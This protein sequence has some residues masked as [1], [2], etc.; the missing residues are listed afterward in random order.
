MSPRLLQLGCAAFVVELAAIAT[1]AWIAG[2][3]AAMG[4]TAVAFATRLMVRFIAGRRPHT[5]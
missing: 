3:P 5:S 1:L 2:I 4:A